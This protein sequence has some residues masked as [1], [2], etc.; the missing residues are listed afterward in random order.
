MATLVAVSVSG[1]AV[2]GDWA[3]AMVTP[4]GSRL[5]KARLIRRIMAIKRSFWA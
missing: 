4:P 1:V 3:W 2:S 5:E